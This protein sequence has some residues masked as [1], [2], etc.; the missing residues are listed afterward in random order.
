MRFDGVGVWVHS[1]SGNGSNLGNVPLSSLDKYLKGYFPTAALYTLKG[2]PPPVP[3]PYRKVQRVVTT[4][5]VGAASGV[6][7]DNVQLPQDFKFSAGI[8]F[9]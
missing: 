9:C 7:P 2:I 6:L 3:F 5:L 4:G 8:V 1:S